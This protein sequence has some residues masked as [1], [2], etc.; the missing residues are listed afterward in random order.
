MAIG[1]KAKDVMT[2]G[3]FV[4]K[5]DTTV[6]K[7]AEIMSRA[8]IGSIVLTEKDKV[9]GILTEGDIVHDVVAKGLDPDKVKIDKVAKSPVRTVDPDKDVEDVARIMRDLNVKRLPVVRKGKLIGIV[10]ER[11]LIGVS[12][13]L[14]DIM[15]ERASLEERPSFERGEIATGECESCGNYSTN[16]QRADDKFL[17]E[18][19]REEGE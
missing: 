4:T 18:D 5:K 17:C 2:R 14:Y 3:V 6:R 13:A 7:A 15:F 9:T 12:P 16:L 11:D 1:I 10:T 19:C 8:N